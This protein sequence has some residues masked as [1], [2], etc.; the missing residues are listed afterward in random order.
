[1]AWNLD[2]S[3]QRSKPKQGLEALGEHFYHVT[4]V[5]KKLLTNKIYRRFL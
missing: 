1:M 3:V 2:Q 4:V 5:G